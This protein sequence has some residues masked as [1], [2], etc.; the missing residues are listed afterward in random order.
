MSVMTLMMVILINNNDNNV[1]SAVIVRFLPTSFDDCR[2]A[3]S[4]CQVN[5]HL[6][7]A[8]IYSHHCHLSLLNTCR[9]THSTLYHFEHPAS[10]SSSPV[11]GP[12]AD[13]VLPVYTGVPLSA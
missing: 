5:G 6:S 7:A 12:T 10:L 8:I 1:C 4:G 3:P 9:L 11:V 13:Q 2:T